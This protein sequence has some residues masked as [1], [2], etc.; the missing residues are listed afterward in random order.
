KQTELGM[1][2]PVVK[3]ATVEDPILLQII[4]GRDKAEYLQLYY[5]QYLPPA[6][7]SVVNDIVQGIMAK[8]MTPEEACQMLEDSAVENL[9]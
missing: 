3:G 7:G 4:E 5:D 8:A 2:V 1:G 9:D 6:M